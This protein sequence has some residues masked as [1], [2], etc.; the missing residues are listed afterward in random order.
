M[1]AIAPSP[2]DGLTVP[3]TQIEAALRRAGRQRRTATR[4]ATIAAAL[5][6]TQLRQDPVVEQAMRAE[7]V[8]LLG[9]LNAACDSAEQLAAA[10]GEAFRQHPDHETITSFPGLADVSGAIVL[11]EIGDDRNRFSDDRALQAFAGSAPITR[12]PPANPAP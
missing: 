7:T 12:A 6:T 8:A 3:K 11:A 10:L 1:L 5:R 9:V 4:A 2:A